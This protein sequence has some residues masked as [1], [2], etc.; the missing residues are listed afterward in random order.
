MLQDLFEKEAR[1]SAAMGSRDVAMVVAQ[2]TPP[3]PSVSVYS[4]FERMVK[5]LFG[6]LLAPGEVLGQLLFSKAASTYIEPAGPV[7]C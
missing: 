6:I 7:T 3:P 4:F 1:Y 5:P 2:K